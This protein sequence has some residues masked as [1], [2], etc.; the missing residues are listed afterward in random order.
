MHAPPG[1]F[2][3]SGYQSNTFLKQ[4]YHSTQWVNRG[5][6]G[7]EAGRRFLLFVKFRRRKILKRNA[8]WH[9][10]KFC[11][12]ISNR[13]PSILLQMAFPP[14]TFSFKN[15][16]CVSLLQLVDAVGAHDRNESEETICAEK[17]LTKHELTIVIVQPSSATSS[18]SIFK[19]K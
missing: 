4:K 3:T 2:P 17:R 9:Q 11:T 18:T 15:A 16:S 5:L 6:C 19:N 12:T 10:L 13:Y 8:T 1:C 7:F 14:T